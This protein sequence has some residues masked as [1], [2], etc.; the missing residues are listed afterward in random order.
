MIFISRAT[1]RTNLQVRIYFEH[2]DPNSRPLAFPGEYPPTAELSIRSETELI[3]VILILIR[4]FTMF[5]L[6]YILLKKPHC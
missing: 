2:C 4:A 6:Y 5:R 3:L 1:N